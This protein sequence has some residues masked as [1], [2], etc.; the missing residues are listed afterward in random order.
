[1]KLLLTRWFAAL[2][3]FLVAWPSGVAGAYDGWERRE[4]P[5]GDGI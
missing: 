5:H 4:F 3:R 2:T 1:M